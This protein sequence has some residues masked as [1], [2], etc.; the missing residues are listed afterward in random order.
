MR[1]VANLASAVRFVVRIAVEV[2]DYLN[3]K[4]EHRQD[5]RYGEQTKLQTLGD[6]K[7]PMI[8]KLRDRLQVFCH[9]G[10]T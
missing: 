1:D 5:Q 10:F 9:L 4:N 2:N 6:H 7:T 8:T 3:P